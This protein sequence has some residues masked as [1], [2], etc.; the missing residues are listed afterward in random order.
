M[1]AMT[2]PVLIGTS[3]W[4]YPHWRRRL[5]PSRLPQSRWLEHYASH[6]STVEVNNSFY[7]LPT[8][9]VFNAWRRRTPDGFVFAVKASRFIT[10]VKRLRDPE[11]PLKTLIGR[12]R[13]L[14][15]KLGPI[16]FQLPPRFRLDLPRLER[17][18]HALPGHVHAVIE[19]RDPSWHVPE[20]YDLLQRFR[21]GYCIMIGPRLPCVPMVTGRLLYARFHSPGGAGPAFGRRRLRAWARLFDALLRDADAGYIYFNNDARGA[22]VED[23]HTLCAL[24]RV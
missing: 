23:A 17:F 14:E 3:G 24:M 16:L 4:V 12:A 9:D 13:H 2:A 8:A 21:V 7:R 5:Y 19:F 22:A 20:V 15:T 11:S 1:P 18:L 6:F 10:H